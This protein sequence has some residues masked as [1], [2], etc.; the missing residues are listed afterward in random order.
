MATI[1][2]AHVIGEALSLGSLTVGKRCSLFVLSGEDVRDL[3]YRPGAPLAWA[4]VES[5]RVLI[6]QG[7]PTEE[8]AT[9]TIS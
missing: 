5:G 3:V 7:R 2:A 1:N 8:V 4:V 6:G 9:W